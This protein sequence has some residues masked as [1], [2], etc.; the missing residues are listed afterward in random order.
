MRMLEEK[1]AEWREE[2]PDDPHGVKAID[3]EL[4][5]RGQIV[6]NENL[7]ARMRSVFTDDRPKEAPLPASWKKL[8]G[9]KWG[10]WIVHSVVPIPGTLLRVQSKEREPVLARVKKI[11]WHGETLDGMTESLCEIVREGE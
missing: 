9:G 2:N 7:M 1:A 5:K 8:P 4:N 11:Q 10:A 3:H 6:P